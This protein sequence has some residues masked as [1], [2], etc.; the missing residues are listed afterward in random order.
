MINLQ[1]TKRTDERLKQLMNVHY[2]K[3]KGF[4][5][6]NIC[7]AIMHD[8]NYYGHI[9]GGSCTLNLPGRDKFFSI[10]KKDYNRIVNNIFYH[11]RKV[12]GAY[13]MRNF[14]TKVLQTWRDK[15]SEDWKL[16]YSNSVIGFESLIEPPRTADLYKK[17]KWTYLGR[18]KGYTCKRVS[19]KETG[20][21]SGKRIWDYN[22]LRPKLVYARKV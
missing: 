10:E 22:N 4:V 3:P 19:G 21:Y 20:K 15:I 11:I 7:Y 9:I 1:V 2:S 6:R 16:K 12:N 5:G 14:T 13:P 8:H 18:T 17:D